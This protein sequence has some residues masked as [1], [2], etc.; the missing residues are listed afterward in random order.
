MSYR[1]RKT[2]HPSKILNPALCIDISKYCIYEVEE[3]IGN[4][5]YARVTEIRVVRMIREEVMNVYKS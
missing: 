3:H 4:E 5:V 2:I 1:S